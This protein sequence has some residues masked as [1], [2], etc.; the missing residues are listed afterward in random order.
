M[1]GKISRRVRAS[2]AVVGLFAGLGFS[3]DVLYPDMFSLSDVQLLGGVLKDRQDLNVE[4]LLSY[5]TDRL[6]APF[7]EEAGMKPKATKFPNWAG[8]DG[9][10]LGHYLSALAMH[11]ADNADVQVKDRLDYIIK[12]LKTIQDQNSKDNNFKGYISGV[13]NGKA[14][15]LKMKNGDA[16]AQNGY[17]VPWYNIHKLYAGLRDAYVYAGV[18]QAKTMFLALCDWGITITNGLND[19][20]M[21]SMLGTEHGGM[22]EV[23]ADA[24]EL[25]K[26]SKYLDA[27]KKW[28]HKWLLNAMAAGNDNLTNVHANT[29]VPKVVGFARV[30]ELSGDQTYV[31]GA[32]FFW[33]RVVHKRSIAIGGNSISEHFP[34]LNNHKKY[35]EEREGPESCNTYNMLKLTE[36]LFAMKHDADYADF[37]E[38][39][40]FNHILSTIHPEHGGYVYFTPARPRHYR[41][42]SK[43]NAGMWC[44]VGS[45]MENP[46][47]Y[48][49]FIYTKAKD[50]LFVN[51]FAASNLSWKE[52]SL[53]IKQETE[54][55]KG[56]SSKFTVTGSGSFDFLIR[57]PYWVKEDAFKVIVNGDT[58]VSKSKP[59][60]YVSAGKS[61]KSGDVIEVLYP[62]YTHVEDLPGVSDYV[63]LLHG[64]I[65]LSAKTGTANLN[66]LV[67]DDGRW[68]HIASG[69]LEAL[70]QAPM[71][72]SKKEDIPS[73]LEPV[74][75]EPLHFKAPYLFAAQKDASLLLQPFYEVHDARYM[76]YWMVL[77]DPT[78]LEKL[79]KEQEAAI[80]LDEKTV[81]KVAPGEQQPEVDHKMKTENT[82]SG[83]ANGEFYRDAGKCNAGDGGY[84]SYEFETNSED[85]LSLMVRYWGNEGCKREFDILIDGEKLVTESITDKW[86]VNEFKNVTYP[87]PDSMVKGKKIVTVMFKAGAGSMAGGIYSV[88]LLRNK[89]KPEPVET[90]GIAGAAKN[91]AKS[92]PGFRARA[93]SELL[94]VEADFP[95]QGSLSLKIFSL[96]GR[97]VKSRNLEAGQKSFNIGISELGKG[98]YILR[99]MQG[100]AVYSNT[101]FSKMGGM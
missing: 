8:L 17:W 20:K 34:D 70:D 49:Q 16:G 40:L 78:I 85:S 44:C 47:K 41:V 38:R 69:A 26:D 71:L 61:W 86:K 3:Q 72:A 99:I 97:L 45:G 18:E 55:P 33:Q 1:F 98:A 57:H 94:E 90:L 39:A 68:S 46:A 10:V 11:Y 35:T 28:S 6:L 75:G 65:V 64:P 101:I 48:S 12:E 4:T 93:T 32:D 80:A 54:F 73:K 25:T 24:Y 76:M 7:Y 53:S 30:A 52:K 81:D 96:D 83:T 29:Q 79:Q 58:V 84:I 59:S 27:A 89:P 9:H 82:S 36:R 21:E 62:M 51:L 31:K 91:A 92:V 60:S 67:A 88:R 2:L 15:W 63:A 50:T 77:T 37:Y 74:K 66:G 95:L 22:P 43:V 5:D 56:E 13:P 100:G 23:Y 42:Y 14:M 87:I 19:S